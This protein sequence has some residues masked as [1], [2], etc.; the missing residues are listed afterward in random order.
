MRTL[1]TVG[2]ALSLV[3]IMGLSASA[4]TVAGGGLFVESEEGASGKLTIGGELRTRMEVWQNFTD[5]DSGLADHLSY[6]DARVRLNLG[7]ELT[8]GVQVVV[9]PQARYIWGGWSGLNSPDFGSLAAEIPFLDDRDSFDLYQAYMKWGFELFGRQMELT[10]GRME[11]PLGSEMLFGDDS[12][13]AGLSWDAVRLD[14]QV[15]DNLT[16]TLA[17]KKV[18]EN[19]AFILAGA[20]SVYPAGYING[21]KMYNNDLD[22]F[23]VWS[24]YELSEDALV[25]LYLAY[26]S[27]K[28][29]GGWW[30]GDPLYTAYGLEAKIW[31]LGSRV[32]FDKLV[33]FGQTFDASVELAVQTGKLTDGNNLLSPPW[34]TKLD[35]QDAFAFEAEV[36]WS[37]AMAWSPRL[38][39]GMAWAS[40]DD[41]GSDGNYNHFN[42]LS[43]DVQ[44]R[45]GKAD[46]FVLENIRCV[47]ADLTCK[48]MDMEKLSAGITYLKFNAFEEYDDQGVGGNFM[49]GGNNVNDVADEFDIYAGYK[50]NEN[51]E[52]KLCWSYIDPADQISGGGSENNSPANRVHLTLVVDF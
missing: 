16:T 11:M 42:S 1:G 35:I 40:G 14:I 52:A 23:I 28:N 15:M 17:V 44:G 4:G 5:F 41:D 21:S 22:T 13:Y 2:L 47:Y 12:K 51:V 27:D 43:Q 20:S 10:V 34:E 24:T 8:S 26:T 25:D 18:V 3:A 39:I 29:A 19:D 38:A 31:T 50:L 9:T 46:M 6:V 30:S 33:L 48:P 32:K 45:L 7:F 37:P 36:G 49:V